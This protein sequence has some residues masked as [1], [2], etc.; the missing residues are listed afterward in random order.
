VLALMEVPRD[1]VD[2]Y[3][4][5]VV[6]GEG[7]ILKVT[8]LVEKP[9]VDE[10][11]SNLILI[12]RYVLPPTIFGAIAET[13]PGRGNEI[14]LTDAMVRLLEAGTPVHGVVFRGTRYDT[15]EPAGYLQAVV[16][17]ACQRDD[18]GAFR[19][20]LTRFVETQIQ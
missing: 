13:K 5:A 1:Q 9:P 19:D 15:G 12:G 7:D 14:Q 10:A 17:L 20:W 4:V 16:Q 8:G 2:R 3:G 11:P 6:E 18:L